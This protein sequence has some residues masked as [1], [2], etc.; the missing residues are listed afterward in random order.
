MLP[1]GT[2][3]KNPR[4]QSMM[5]MQ[6]RMELLKL[7]HL[8]FHLSNSLPLIQ[9]ASETHPILR[10]YMHRYMGVMQHVVQ[11]SIGYY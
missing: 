5:E 4:D 3:I 6:F 2:M 9:R 1:N 11:G 7:A 8:Q 10:S